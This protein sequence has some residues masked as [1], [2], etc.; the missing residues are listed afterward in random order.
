MFLLTE[1]GENEFPFELY[2]SCRQAFFEI[3]Q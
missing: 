1:G 2:F 3:K